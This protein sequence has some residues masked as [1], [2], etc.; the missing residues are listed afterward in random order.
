LGIEQGD[1]ISRSTVQRTRI[2]DAGG[3]NA[4]V[5]DFVRVSV[6]QIVYSVLQGR[7]DQVHVMTVRERNALAGDF[8]VT[9]W[10]ANFHTQ[11]LG[12]PGERTFIVAI[13]ENDLGWGG[14]EF[15][16]D[17]FASDV[18]KVNEHVSVSVQKPLHRPAGGVSTTV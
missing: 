3:T 15:F 17:F 10:V 13:A 11:S 14:D 1:S 12:M 7:F 4:F 16:K 5:A 8:E 2:D 6:Q 18:P 9:D